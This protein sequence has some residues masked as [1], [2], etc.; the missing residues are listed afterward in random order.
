[1]I[2]LTNNESNKNKNTFKEKI[3]SNYKDEETHH[4]EDK[5]DKVDKIVHKLMKST[6]LQ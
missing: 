5:D 4:A 6:H 3:A 1:M 2:S